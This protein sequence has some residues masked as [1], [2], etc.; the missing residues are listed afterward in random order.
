MV[1]I[2][3]EGFQSMIPELN[4]TLIKLAELIRRS[5]RM[6]ILND[7]NM[8]DDDKV[9]FTQYL[10]FVRP[11]SVLKY[12]KSI[13]IYGTF[14][15]HFFDW[16]NLDPFAMELENLAVKMKFSGNKK[17][18]LRTTRFINGC[19]V[20][21][22]TNG[23]TASDL[24]VLRNFENELSQFRGV[25]LQEDALSKYEKIVHIKK[26]LIRLDFQKDNSLFISKLLEL[27]NAQELYCWDGL[28]HPFVKFSLSR[29]KSSFQLIIPDSVAV[30]KGINST[31]SYAWFIPELTRY[32]TSEIPYDFVYEKKVFLSFQEKQIICESLISFFYDFSEF[33]PSDFYNNL[34]KCFFPAKVIEEFIASFISSNQSLLSKFIQNP[35]KCIKKALGIRDTFVSTQEIFRRVF[36]LH[37]DNVSKLKQSILFDLEISDQTRL[38]AT[39]ILLSKSSI[40]EMESMIQLPFATFFPH[41]LLPNGF[42]VSISSCWLAEE[43]FMENRLSTQELIIS[44]KSFSTEAIERLQSLQIDSIA[45]KISA[46]TITLNLDYFEFELNFYALEFFHHCQLNSRYDDFKIKRIIMPQYDNQVLEK[47]AELFGESIE[48]LSIALHYDVPIAELSD[49]ILKFAV[50]ELIEMEEPLVIWYIHEKL[51]RLDLY[52]QIQFRVNKATFETFLSIKEIHFEEDLIPLDVNEVSIS[53]ESH[54]FTLITVGVAPFAPKQKAIYHEHQ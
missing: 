23:A 9:I 41:L 39:K 26:V 14:V 4:L 21:L 27:L 30:K 17:I 38:S 1:L 34:F 42:K 5:V 22:D 2:N 51:K 53:M 19:Y 20:I 46:D 52:K 18:S 7:E 47:C 33:H 49:L 28:E 15:V 24:N 43:I 12:R 44:I 50:I 40:Y 25:I 11:K 8:T 37:L 36:D 16:I 13:Y 48:S 35:Y 45:S 54:G 10:L 3:K 32:L 6:G 31:S 29:E